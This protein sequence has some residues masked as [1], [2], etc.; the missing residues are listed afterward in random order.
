MKVVIGSDKKGFNLKEQVKKYL[1]DH[2]YE[3]IGNQ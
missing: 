2:S 3:V 1:L